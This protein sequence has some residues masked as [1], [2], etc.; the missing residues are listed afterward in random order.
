MIENL[1]LDARIRRAKQY[2]PQR[3]GVCN[4]LKR[5]SI[6]AINLDTVSIKKWVLATTKQFHTVNFEENILIL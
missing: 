3:E 6:V 4:Y 1:N 5:N 2:G